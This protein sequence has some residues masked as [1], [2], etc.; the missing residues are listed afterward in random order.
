MQTLPLSGAAAATLREKIGGKTA[1][2]GIIGLGY[3]G[4][5]LAMEF[6][7]AGFDVTGIDVLDHKVDQLNAGTSYVQDVPTDLVRKYVD[8]GRFRATT[9][10]SIL[11]EMDTIN[12]AVPTPL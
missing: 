1:K 4:L 3:V 6:A 10:F 8:E 9:E 11:S 2:V 5:P 7:R 12:I